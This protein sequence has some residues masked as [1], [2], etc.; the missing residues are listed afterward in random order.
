MFTSDDRIR[1]KDNL[2]TIKDRIATAAKRSGQNVE[3]IMLVAVSKNFP[4]DAI[5]VAIEE[6]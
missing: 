2:N 5:E 3:D 4:V 6:K 1:I